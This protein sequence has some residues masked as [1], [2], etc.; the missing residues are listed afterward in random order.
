VV[1]EMTAPEEPEM[2]ETTRRNTAEGQEE[3]EV[4]EDHVLS[5]CCP[6]RLRLLQ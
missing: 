6:E 2:K 4:P 3:E 5:V 1:Q